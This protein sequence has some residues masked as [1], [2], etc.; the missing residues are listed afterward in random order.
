[1][2]LLLT[3][4]GVL[5]DDRTCP[6]VRS[7]H[8]RQDDRMTLIW[9]SPFAPQASQRPATKPLPQNANVEGRRCEI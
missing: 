5:D 2:K 9:R 3:F 6:G 7:Q 8:R 4:T 1:M